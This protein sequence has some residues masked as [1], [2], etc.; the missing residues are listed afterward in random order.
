[1]TPEM[2]GKLYLAPKGADMVEYAGKVANAM[3][4]GFLGYV[5]RL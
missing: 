4:S 3:R 2:F 1:M 5:G